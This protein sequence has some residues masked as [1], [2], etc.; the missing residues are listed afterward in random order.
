MPD[1]F[2][3]TTT[4]DPLLRQAFLFLLNLVEKQAAQIQALQIENQAL[5]DENNH[6]KGEQGKP[7][8]LPN[9]K[10]GNISSE[11]E[12]RTPRTRPA[13]HTNHYQS[14]DRTLVLRLDR[15]SLPQD[16][17]PKGYE[18][19]LVKD[20]IIQPETVCFRREKF[21][22]P[23]LHRTFVA[24]LPDG[25]TNGQYGPGVHTL[26]L[27]LYYQSGLSEPKIRQLLLNLGIP[28]SAGLLSEWLIHQTTE[29]ETEARAVLVA[30]LASSAWQQLDDTSTR[31]NGINQACLVLC[32]PLYTYYHTN[33]SKKRLSVLRVLVGGKLSYCFNEEARALLAAWQVPLKWLAQLPKQWPT[34][35]NVLSEA[36]LDAWLSKHLPKLSKQLDRQ[37]REGLGLAYY[38]A[39][40]EWPVVDLLVGDDAPQWEWLS[41]ELSACWVHLG[42]HYKKLKPQNGYFQQVLEAFLTKF[43]EYYRQL[44][45]YKGDP[46]PSEA[47]RLQAEFRQLFTTKTDYLDLNKRNAQT[48][49]KLGPLLVV[50]THPEIPL[51]NNAS[52]LAARQRVRKRDVSFG[53]RTESGKTAWDSLQSLVETCH[54]LGVNFYRYVHSRLTKSSEIAPLANLIKARAAELNLSASWATF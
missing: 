28:I 49:A 22:S 36:E 5:R 52:E 1:N 32:N 14:V 40:T 15:D 26:V 43:W 11:A 50:L 38:H 45:D 6:L 8:I 13:K 53:P 46:S 12:R 25:Y 42:R 20:I 33:P 17:Q 39:Q 31:V 23:S 37:I 19:V 48:V 3:P 29:F 7:K 18:E 9:K 27:S 30:G 10:Q 16:A 41:P 51:H 47:V 24:E 35:P 34:T 44:L 54:K 21:Y 4:F 2:D